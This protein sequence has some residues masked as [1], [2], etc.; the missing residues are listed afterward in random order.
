[1]TASEPQG[2]VDSGATEGL[3][4]VPGQTYTMGSDRH[5]PEESPAHP[6][7]VD[8]FWLETHQVTN[9]QFAT[10][11][12]ATGYLTV[13]ERPLNPADFP[14]APRREPA[15]RFDGLHQDTWSG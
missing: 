13:A 9:A 11:A 7:A 6:V 15:A 1:V 2:L 3:R 10:F 4:W 12:D 5:Y 8:G 14:G